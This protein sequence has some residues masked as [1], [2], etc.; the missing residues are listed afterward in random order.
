MSIN[1]KTKSKE[2]TCEQLFTKCEIDIS[3]SMRFKL[4]VVSFEKEDP[5]YIS[6]EKAFEAVG[7][8]DQT[9]QIIRS[10]SAKVRFIFKPFLNKSSLTD[11]F[12]NRE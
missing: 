3:D 10:T 1:L 9:Q 2:W 12:S 7:F 4:N 6:Q 5:T 8:F 11:L